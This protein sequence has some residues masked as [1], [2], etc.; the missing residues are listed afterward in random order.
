MEHAVS[1]GQAA[2]QPGWRQS[3]WLSA[4]EF[5]IGAGL[6]IGHNVYHVLPNEVPILFV[7]GWISIHFRNGGWKTVGL[8]RPKS[9]KRTALFVVGAAAVRILLGVFLTDPISA[10]IWPPEKT[11]SVISRAHGDWKAMLVA[12]LI[13]WTFAS[14]G[15]ELGYRGYLLNRGAE[16]G[17]RSTIAYWI[18]ML[19]VAVLFGYGHWYKGPGAILDSGTAGLVLGGAYLLSRRNLWVPVLAHG[20]IDTA[21]VIATFLGWTN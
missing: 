13:V 2:V 21:V 6:V 9:W 11:S 18:S 19:A 17:N 5:L 12:L 8:E 3:R 14:F 10:R 4:T 16:V 15:E 20:L 7:L 1:V